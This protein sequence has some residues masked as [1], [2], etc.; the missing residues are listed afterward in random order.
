MSTEYPGIPRAAKDY[1]S[2]YLRVLIPFAIFVAVIG[3]LGAFIIAL[4]YPDLIFFYA[5]ALVSICLHMSALYVRDVWS[6]EYDPGQAQFASGGQ[7][8]GIIAVIGVVGSFLL[9]LGTG[10]AAAAAGLGV[11]ILI[12][13]GL[14]AYYPVIDVI[15]MR[16][17]IRTPTWLIGYITVWFIIG[18]ANMPGSLFD[19]LPV[20]GKRRPPSA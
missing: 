8:L 3:S 6:E 18:S 16:N 13:T 11:P 10:I 5:T 12:A 15:L 2:S 20:I 19:S 4:F 14:A 7:L 1:F 17:N 9:L